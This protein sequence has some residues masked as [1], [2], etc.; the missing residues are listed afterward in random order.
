MLA[1]MML[2]DKE[3]AQARDAMEAFTEAGTP[4]QY[5]LAR[6]F[7]ALAD[8]Y[9]GLGDKALA[10]EFVSSLR[11][12]YPGSEQDIADMISSRLNKWK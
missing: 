1:E 5:W 11:E 6:G 10:R 7:I 3:Y 8:A 2:A 4:H 12:N 9:H